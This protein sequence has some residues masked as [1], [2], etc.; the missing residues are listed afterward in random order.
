LPDAPIPDAPTKVSRMPLRVIVP[1]LVM[2]VLGGAFALAFFSSAF[3]TAPLNVEMN[4][5]EALE[6]SRALAS[7]F[8]WGPQDPRSAVSFVS[9][10]YAQIF[11]ELEGGG[12][13]VFRELIHEHLVEPYTWHVR[14]F[15]QAEANEVS[16][17]FTPEGAPFGFNETIPE[18][19]PG[20]EIAV[21]AARALA[22][23][24]A[25]DHFAVDFDDYEPLEAERQILPSERADHRFTYQHK[26][27]DLGEGALRLW[28]TVSGDR[29]TRLW[30]GVEVPE[31]FNRRYTNMRSQNQTLAQLGRIGWC[32]L[33]GVGA[34]ALYVVMR[35]RGV[36]W[37]PGLIAG[38]AVSFL[39]LLSGLNDLPL[40]WSAFDTATSVDTH[41]AQFVLS[42]L[43]GFVFT[44]T[45]LSLTLVLA[46][47]LNRE[48][49]PKRAFGWK[50][51]S[52]VVLR[53][54]SVR[55]SILLGYA[56]V[57][58]FFAYEVLLYGVSAQAFGWWLPMRQ[59]VSPNIL[60]TPFP[61]LG[62]ISG[63]LQAGLWEECLF[64]AIP[65][66]GAMV[67]GKRF[68]IQRSL[69]VV[70]VVGQAIV[71][72]LAHASYA[73]QPAYARVV[74]LLIPSL[75]FAF[76][77]LRFGLIAGV[78][79]HFVYDVIWMALP[80]L[81]SSA[82]GAFPHQA[83]VVVLALVPIGL[84]ARAAIAGGRT[85]SSED[86]L[87]V[88]FSNEGQ[89]SRMRAEPAKPA[90][91]VASEWRPQSTRIWIAI[92]LLGFGSWVANARF[93]TD[94]PAFQLERA[95]VAERA[96]TALSAQGYEIDASWRE[97][98]RVH[99]EIGADARFVWDEARADYERL[100][101]S[102]V[103]APYWFVWYGRFEGDVAEREEEYGVALGSN[104]DV[105]GVWHHPPE[106]R[107]GP[108]LAEDEARALALAAV[109]ARFGE[110]SYEEI[111]AS[112][113][114]RPA[115]DDWFFEYADRS[116]WTHAEAEARI[117]VT[118][119][120]DEVGEAYR[121]FSVP[122]PWQRA[123]RDRRARQ[124][125]LV[126]ALAPVMLLLFGCAIAAVLANGSRERFSKRIF[127]VLTGISAAAVMI[128]LW[129]AWPRH[130]AH[131][132]TALDWSTQ[133][134]ELIL[135]RIILVAG[136]GL[137][138]L[139]AG[140][141]QP[142]SSGNRLPILVALGLGLAGAGHGALRVALFSSGPIWGSY[143]GAPTIYPWLS[144]VLNHLRDYVL[145]V[146]LSMMLFW[147]YDW[148][149]A[150]WTRRRAAT[151]A[152]MI[153]LT[154]LLLHDASL[155]SIQSSLLSGLMAAV[156]LWGA[157]VF[158]YRYDLSLVPLA[159]AAGFGLDSIATAVK[160]TH[161]GAG[162]GAVVAGVAALLLGSWWTWEQR[163]G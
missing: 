29:V 34:A 122:E 67:L 109:I 20:E 96:R 85:S 94:A 18:D 72:G 43:A 163:R 119:S 97:L 111:L 22:E 69:V 89:A 113:D 153:V 105:L 149:S 104:G 90:P 148:M 102:Y 73:A 124:N 160:A 92:G 30:R 137:V 47:G 121:F 23:S 26:G 36:D 152:A 7:Q 14:L 127:L 133:S 54:P 19:W 33:L 9:A 156:F 41:V 145:V 83:I 60:A 158:V 100:L 144:D 51:L 130:I 74:E 103:D 150:N 115:R 155:A 37:R 110:S 136:C 91:R 71:F 16:V 8:G 138:A 49:F 131:F 116:A 63:A 126:L 12:P 93:A 157:Y 78:I 140:I 5:G 114:H 32:M 56:F 82:H 48:A 25:R 117:H 99:D 15:Q 118:I 21:D 101:G 79:L 59:G 132:D 88:E 40:S 44:S 159:T 70:F 162:M 120:G 112:K 107:E 24:F 84:V 38:V 161:P 17:F 108:R 11:V 139:A 154:T 146:M 147:V 98:I 123:Q 53:S 64:R 125:L 45:L 6:R 31:A 143:L 4:R 87:P 77:Y 35:G 151:S 42:R 2:S 106:Q 61:W 86:V 3:P 75:G 65:I 68:G 134:N 141:M 10:D 76:L 27:V 135:M 95:D 142:V 55:R 128:G 46:D 28:M 62:P 39:E 81:T 80:L 13:A 58:V 52:P 66:A 1:I 129:N 57:P 50:I